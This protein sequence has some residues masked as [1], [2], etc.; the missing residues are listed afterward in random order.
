MTL[1]APHAPKGRA[2]S[3][4]RG[5]RFDIHLSLTS[6][7]RSDRTFVHADHSSGTFLRQPQNSRCVAKRNSQICP[8]FFQR[9]AG[10]LRFG[11]VLWRSCHR[12]PP[13]RRWAGLATAGGSGSHERLGMRPLLQSSRIFLD[14][15]LGCHLPLSQ[16]ERDD[17]WISSFS[18]RSAGVM[19]CRASS[20][21]SKSGPLV[22]LVGTRLELSNSNQDARANRHGPTDV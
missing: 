4:C 14:F 18:A 7:P 12:A 8:R 15:A 19:P 3:R 2:D 21:R 10:G 1:T 13:A 5:D 22:F 16:T 20:A 9:R 6:E 17:F 11:V